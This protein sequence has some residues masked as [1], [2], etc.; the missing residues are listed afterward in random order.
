[1]GNNIKTDLKEI[2]CDWIQVAQD[3]FHWRDLINTVSK[4]LAS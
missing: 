2:G 1:M 4:L 3:R